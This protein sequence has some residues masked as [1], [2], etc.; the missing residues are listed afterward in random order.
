MSRNLAPVLIGRLGSLV[1]TRSV[2][3]R[4]HAAGGIGRSGNSAIS[5]VPLGS[6][7]P[8]TLSDPRRHRYASRI[9]PLGEAQNSISWHHARWAPVDFPAIKQMCDAQ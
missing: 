5:G 4:T 3:A 9:P 8:S 1:V 6:A 2:R 7:N